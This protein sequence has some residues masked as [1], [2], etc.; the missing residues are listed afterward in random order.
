MIID[1][2]HDTRV[3]AET[4]FGEIRHVIYGLSPSDSYKIQVA[5]V[6]SNGST[7]TASP[8]IYEYM[9]YPAESES[10]VYLNVYIPSPLW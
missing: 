8:G 1:S 2:Y 6:N 3:P 9:P 5:A 10:L 7:G 4:H